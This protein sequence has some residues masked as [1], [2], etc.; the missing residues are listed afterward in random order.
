MQE[1]SI[2][3]RE[4]AVVAHYHLNMLFLVVLKFDL[5]LLFNLQV[6]LLFQELVHRL[7]LKELIQEV[8]YLRLSGC[9]ICIFGQL[10]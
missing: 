8:F 2:R 10:E 4:R 9:V 7:Q 6:Q 1:E 5:N 3:E